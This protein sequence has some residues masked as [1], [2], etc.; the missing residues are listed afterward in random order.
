MD[1]PQAECWSKLSLRQKHRS[2][3][4]VGI[5]SSRKGLQCKRWEL[6]AKANARLL[7]FRCDGTDGAKNIFEL[8]HE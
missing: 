1:A 6:L 3:V 8:M 2:S 7:C 4:H 5:I